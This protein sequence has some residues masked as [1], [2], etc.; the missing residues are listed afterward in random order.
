MAR[1]RPKFSV[2]PKED[3]GD[4]SGRFEISDH[5]LL[6]KLYME[7]KALRSEINALRLEARAEFDDVDMGS[8]EHEKRI[9]ALENWR[10]Y[11][12]GIGC[13]LVVFY[14][15]SDVLIKLLK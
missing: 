12:L 10:W 1:F 5:D 6:I 2:V 7:V 13:A 14:K 9:R 15:I 11:M 8:G 4:D 3:D